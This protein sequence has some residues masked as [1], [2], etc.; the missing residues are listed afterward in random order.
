MLEECENDY[1]EPVA[2]ACKLAVKTAYYYYY[3]KKIT[4]K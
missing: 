3:Y 4:S 1:I 2:T